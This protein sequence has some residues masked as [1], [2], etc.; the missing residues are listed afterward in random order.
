MKSTRETTA[1]I[2]IIGGGTI[3]AAT[4]LHLTQRGAQVTIYDR[5]SPPHSTGSHVGES[6]LLRRLPYLEKTPVEQQ[7]LKNSLA[8][9]EEL[10][11]QTGQGL[12]THCGG[13]II[14]SSKAERLKA[15]RDLSSQDVEYL[16]NEEFLTR[17]PQF[18]DAASQAAVL[19]TKAGII[20]PQAAISATLALAKSKGANFSFSNEVQAVEEEANSVRVKSR[21]GQ[22]Y[23]DGVIVCAGAYSKQIIPSL[24]IIARRLILGWFR[25]QS[26]HSSW[27]ESAPSF[28]WT[29][30]EGTF[31]YGGPSY[32]GKTLKIGI[33]LELGNVSDPGAADNLPS[34]TDIAAMRATITEKFPWL[35]PAGDRFEVHIDGWSP[36]KTGLL[37]SQHN[38]QKI[39][40]ATGWSGY[41]FKIAPELGRIAADIVLGATPNSDLQELDPNRFF[42][43]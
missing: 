37:G 23:Y 14:D 7:L 4:A 26:S 39:V 30:P 32:D 3:G 35:D 31:I 8:S 10:E 12:I 42:K 5:S 13:L 21:D 20:D 2:A 9:W 40:L 41:G 6:R 22:N 24:P 38:Q 1:Q 27:L 33:D 28:V 25:P 11:R 19:D 34:E 16:P 36:D 15:L 17:F 29:T 18:Q 43:A